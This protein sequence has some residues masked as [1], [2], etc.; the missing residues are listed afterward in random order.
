MN[1]QPS[2]PGRL[3]HAERFPALQ[4]VDRFLDEHLASARLSGWSEG[5]LFGCHPDPALALVR[6]DC[7]GAVT[8]AALMHWP[9]ASV[10]ATE[11]RCVNGLATRRRASG[12][13]EVVRDVFPTELQQRSC[14][15][16]AAS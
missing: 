2:P 15:V 10:S 14:M 1:A 13:A 5:E 8:I 9:V 11:I 4:I 16:T 3:G 12:F 6:C 7:M